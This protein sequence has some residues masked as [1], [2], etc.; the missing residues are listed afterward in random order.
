M[1]TKVISIIFRAL[2][3]MPIILLL[4]VFIQAVMLY[5]APVRNVKNLKLKVSPNGRYFVDQYEKPFFYLGETCW[6]LFKRLN[7]EELEELLN[8]QGIQLEHTLDS[9]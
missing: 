1:K 6:L 4:A 8:T 2:Y 7:H 9:F 3:L 5:D